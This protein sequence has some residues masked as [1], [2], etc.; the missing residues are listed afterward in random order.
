[1]FSGF[2]RIQYKLHFCDFFW[3]KRFSKIYTLRWTLASLLC[4]TDDVD[5]QY[6]NINSIFVFF[7][8]QTFFKDLYFAVD[9]GV[10]FVRNRWCRSGNIQY[11]L[12]FCDF[13]S[14]KRFSKMYTLRWILASLLC[15]S[16]D[17]NRAVYNI[18]Y[19][20]VFFCAQTFF[21]DLYFAV[22]SGFA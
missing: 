3:S 9:S 13:F 20:F 12:H 19:I 5:F 17:V 18:N 21:K 22:D 15:A 1:M 4:A 7:L 16:D 6:Y 11:K 2:G 8:S 14:P 10:A